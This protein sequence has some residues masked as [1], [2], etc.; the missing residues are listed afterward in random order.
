MSNKSHIKTVK[1]DL[2]DFPVGINLLFH[3]ANCFCTMGGGF[4]ANLKA[5]FPE[6]ADADNAT[7]KGDKEK[8]GTYTTAR[9][10]YEKKTKFIVNLYGQFGMGRE[11]RQADY[12]AIATG[13]ETLYTRIAKSQ[14]DGKKFRLGLPKNMASDLAGGDWAIIEAMV[15]TY[16]N[17]YEVETVIVEFNG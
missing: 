12:E 17:K 11:K 8:L 3:C 9:V 4:A 10:T 14:N 2:L 15:T 7:K 1:G 6:A 16:A 5:K 13:L